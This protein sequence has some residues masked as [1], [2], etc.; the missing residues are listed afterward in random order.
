MRR[1]EYKTIAIRDLEK[2]DAIVEQYLNDGWQ[3][4]GN[5][6]FAEIGYGSFYHQ[7][8]LMITEDEAEQ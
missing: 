5:Q 8:M 2:L 7:P 6:Y 3:L 4:A 1:Y